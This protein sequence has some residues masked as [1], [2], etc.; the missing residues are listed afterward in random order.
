MSGSWTHT[1]TRWLCLLALLAFMAA[2]VGMPYPTGAETYIGGQFGISFP[3]DVTSENIDNACCPAAKGAGLDYKTSAAVGVK[4]GHYFNNLRFLGM[5]FD[6]LH[7]NPHLAQKGAFA[8]EYFRV[9]AYSLNFLLRY[10]GERFQPYLG[11]GPSLMY[12]T[13]NDSTLTRE[14]QRDRKLGI[15]AELGTRYMFR[16][17]VALFGEWRFQH[18]RFHYPE[19]TSFNSYQAAYTAQSLLFGIS[20][21]VEPLFKD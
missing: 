17:N 18:A 6:F 13:A 16:K 19:T 7:S 14:S 5:E 15:N 12:A 1:Q 2:G 8:G 3:R 21:N 11:F 10:P 4:I 9:D 20:F